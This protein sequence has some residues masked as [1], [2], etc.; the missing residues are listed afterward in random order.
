MEGE[1]INALINQVKHSEGDSF[2]CDEQAIVE[3]YEAISENSSLVIKV[4]TVL[5]VLI[6]VVAFMV[7][8]F[9]A[10]IY[11]SSFGLL[12]FGGISLVIG[13]SLNKVKAG[14]FK[15]DSI[16]VTAYLV[17][18][19]L[20]VIGLGIMNVDEN[21]IVLLVVFVALI[22][23]FITQ[24]FTISFISILL[25]NGGI[26]ILMFENE[27]FNLLSVYVAFNCLFFTFWLLNEAKLIT[28]TSMIARL[29]TP[30]RAGMLGSFIGLL[31]LMSFSDALDLPINNIWM[32]SAANVP[33]V[34]FILPR[35]LRLLNVQRKASYI[36]VF[37]LVILV[38]LPTTL[39][40]PS[41]SGAL[42]VLFLCFLVNY[43]A[44]IGL[45]I[46]SLVGFI[47]Q[48]YYDL[49]ATLLT[50]SIILFCV[51]VLFLLTYLFTY[52]KLK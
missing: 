17:G 6:G 3:E 47:G 22:S 13:I 25:L 11:E 8:L 23:L 43:R 46:L 34:L 33:V 9:V 41:I 50:K 48:F 15:L 1:N 32:A 40:S 49:Y 19:L 39:F 20:S 27:A 24:R 51:G 38:L 44:G 45:G 18:I 28:Y 12:T 37:V 10:G 30:V 35:I 14:D 36:M 2:V 4:F 7:F 29:Y 42:V 21:L 5:G 16:S 52:K 31:T 26:V